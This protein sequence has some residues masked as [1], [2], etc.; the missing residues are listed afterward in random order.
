MMTMKQLEM[1]V[2]GDE[3][4]VSALRLAGV[5][6]HYSIKSGQ[7]V[8]REVREALTELMADPEV[9]IVVILEDY[10]QYVEDLVARVRK[11]RKPTPVIIEV[12][13][14][15][16]SIYGDVREHYKSRIRESVGFEV[17]I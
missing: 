5:G 17:E 2:I 9:G 14:K 8:G 4:L 1:A 11:G 13:S 6:R 7:D 16:G 15:L 12:P 10:A 3:E